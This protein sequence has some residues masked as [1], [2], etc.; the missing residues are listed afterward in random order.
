MNVIIKRLLFVLGVTISLAVF[1]IAVWL[2][3]SGAAATIFA[4]FCL[5]GIWVWACIIFPDEGA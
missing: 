2:G 5:A 4:I 1:G 3:G